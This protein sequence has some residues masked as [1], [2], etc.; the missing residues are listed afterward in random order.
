M[1]LGT[2]VS[3]CLIQ[4]AVGAPLRWLEESLA[5]QRLIDP[6]EFSANLSETHSPATDLL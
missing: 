3:E 6:S 1:H 2:E 5:Y 4:S